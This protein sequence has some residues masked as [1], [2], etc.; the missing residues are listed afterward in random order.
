MNQIHSWFS[1]VICLESITV[2]CSLQ[3][4]GDGPGQPCHPEFLLGNPLFI[5]SR[6]RWTREKCTQMYSE[7]RPFSPRRESATTW[8]G[9]WTASSTWPWRRSTR[10][11]WSASSR[12]RPASARTMTVREVLLQLKNPTLAEKDKHCN[13]PTPT[14]IFFSLSI[15]TYKPTVVP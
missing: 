8:T 5:S 10:P 1:F 3:L 4:L 2:L 6:K 7:S 11:S 9:R 15:C 14:L 12:P 13:T